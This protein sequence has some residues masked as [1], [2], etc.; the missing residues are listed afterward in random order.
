MKL[1]GGPSYFVDGG[2]SGLC[3]CVLQ[4]VGRT[5]AGPGTASFSVV[6]LGTSTATSLLTPANTTIRTFNSAR[7]RLAGLSKVIGAGDELD[8]GLAYDLSKN[9]IVPIVIPNSSVAPF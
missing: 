1:A 4:V 5:H 8:Q 3:G 6:N 9:L 2:T 7:P